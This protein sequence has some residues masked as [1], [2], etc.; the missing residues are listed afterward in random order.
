MSSRYERSYSHCPSP[1]GLI[2]QCPRVAVEQRPNALPESKRGRQ[3]QSIEPS[4]ETSAA[5]WQSPISA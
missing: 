4:R 5:L 3:H 1:V 2:E